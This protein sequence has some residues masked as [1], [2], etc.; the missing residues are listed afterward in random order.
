MPSRTRLHMHP[1]VRASPG[2][3]A[4]HRI[5]LAM[6][7]AQARASVLRMAELHALVRSVSL[8]SR[9]LALGS[10][11]LALQPRSPPFV[12]NDSR[13]VRQARSLRLTAVRTRRFER[14]ASRT[15]L[16][17]GK[18]SS[19][20]PGR[21]RPMSATHDS[22]FKMG[23]PWPGT[24]LC[25]FPGASVARGSTPLSQS[26]R[27]RALCVRHCPPPLRVRTYRACSVARGF[28]GRTRT[29]RNPRW[30]R[31]PAFPASLARRSGLE[32]GFPP[33]V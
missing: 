3:D 22:V 33:M 17:N 10:E 14:F 23:T 27:V 32:S 5:E 6:R 20:D 2:P 7:S 12:V 11:L 9:L 4:R 31:P 26:R 25:A 28:P 16:T 1:K 21:S 19:S 13:R 18:V 30:L 24:L 15:P 8:P 29:D